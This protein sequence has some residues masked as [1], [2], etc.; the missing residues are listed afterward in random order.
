MNKELL[1]PDALADKLSKE[2]SD[3]RP[4]I[5]REISDELKAETISKVI[6]M[7]ANAL[8]DQPKRVDLSDIDQVRKRTQDY[9]T[10][11]ADAGVIPTVMGLAAHGYA[12]SRQWVNEYLRNNPGSESAEYIERTKDAFADVLVTSALNRA[13]D[14]TMAIF[15]LKNTNGFADRLEVTPPNPEPPLGRL[16]DQKA[17]EERIMGSVTED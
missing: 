3:K 7:N 14:A 8:K 12:C 6:T 2:K 9:L 10:A 17:L 13:A 5:Y 15:T 4:R 1:P 11:C 16:P